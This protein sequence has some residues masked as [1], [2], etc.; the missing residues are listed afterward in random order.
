MR[1]RDWYMRLTELHALIVPMY[2]ARGL[3][4]PD[5]QD[6]QHQLCEYHKYA[7]IKRGLKTRLKREYKPAVP[8]KTKR[9]KKA[10]SEA[11]PDPR[12]TA[13]EPETETEQQEAETRPNDP[14]PRYPA[15]EAPP[16]AP[17]EIP[18]YIRADMAAVK[19]SASPQPV[20]L[21]QPASPS[22]PLPHRHNSV[23]QKHGD[24]GPPRGGVKATWVYDHPDQPFY[25]L[26]EK[27]VGGNG[28]RKFFQY[29]WTGQRWQIGVKGSYGERKVPYQLCA[30]KAALA[31]DPNVTVHITEG[32]KDADTL[33]RLGFV[34]TT[35]PGGA[36]HWDDDC[37][38]WLRILGAHNI[39]VHEDNDDA[40]RDRSCR[41]A[42]MLSGFSTLR[43]VRYPDVPEGEDV[44]WWLDHHSK[45]ELAARIAAAAVAGPTW[46]RAPIRSWAGQP[47][48]E[49]EF[50]V[51]DR[52]PVEQVCLFSGEGGGGKSAMVEHL[53]AAH[54][55]GREWLGV[56]PRQGPAIYIECEDAMGV[57]HWRLAAVAAYYGVPIESF[58]EDLHLFSLVEDDS[59]LATT[60]KRGIVE[61]TAAYRRLYE[62]AGDIKPVQIGIASLA[63]IFAGS[64]INRTEVQQFI[65]LMNRI[66]A[67]TKGSLTLVSQPSLTGLSS[68]DISHK[69]L[70]GTTQWH[71]AVR[72][73]A[74]VEHVKPKNGEG[75]GI[76]IGLRTLT[77]YKNQ[78]GPP[79]AGTVLRWQQGLFL[80]VGGGV[81]SAAQ[82][83]ELAR[84]LATTL[85]RR[86]TEQHRNVS[87]SP[88]P[89]NYAPT[90]FAQ[91]PEAEGLG[92]VAKDF[93]QA[94]DQLLNEGSIVNAE[95]DKGRGRHC[96]RLAR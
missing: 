71:N 31:A 76:D 7:Q 92:L 1:E 78:Y 28:D 53:C 43:L 25:L 13:A 77:F 90:L 5:F 17:E 93:K 23:G 67:L 63:N 21:S 40:G 65:K 3:P 52:I 33:R 19:P 95:V 29:H 46:K 34:A 69:G 61:P 4:I 41:L 88:N 60:N 58:A 80:P 94:L 32:E 48:P 26:V 56:V 30:L 50:T 72:A 89:T 22:L 96:L 64:E 59:V 81:V 18:D 37:T 75:N 9:G 79:V 85:L 86:F 87:I 20:S 16:I 54:V 44:T 24:A 45:D 66:P 57:L 35:N 91:T 14:G 49:Q 68:S 82:R 83:V 6:L 51:P 84:E 36:T 39:V 73:R 27:R 15:T 2:Q 74:A 70:S 55:L 12:T 47:V 62:M 11:T 10:S 38:A 8:A 42:A